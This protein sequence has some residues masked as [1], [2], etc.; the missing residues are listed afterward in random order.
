MA[1]GRSHEIIRE[2]VSVTWRGLLAL[3][4]SL[5]AAG[6][7]VKVSGRDLEWKIET[8]YFVADM[9]K[10]PGTGRSGQ[11]NTILLRE[12]AVLLTRNRASSTLHL[13][14]N[15]AVGRNWIGVNRW[16]PP[17]KYEAKSTERGYCIE[18]E[19]EMPGGPGLW[20]KVVYEFSSGEPEIW[21]EESIEARTAVEVRLLR[22]GEWSFAPGAEHPFT[23]VA[24]EDSSGAVTVKPRAGEQH[25]PLDIR[26]QA[27]CNAAKGIGFA[28]V[29]EELE[30]PASASYATGAHF[31]GEPHYFYRTVLESKDGGLVQV[32]RGARF[33]MRYRILA[34]KGD[35]PVFLY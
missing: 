10:N 32:P 12:P 21:V 27:F 6:E 16:N 18:R 2:T 19:G 22:M 8:P 13:S 20:V 5:P 15:V 14:P 17:A 11:I 1:E 29:V 33:R 25:L 31:G 4:A 9:G 26:W 30:R 24:W 7:G 35:C 3:L 34:R 23:H 28:A